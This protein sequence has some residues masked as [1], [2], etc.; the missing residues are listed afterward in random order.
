MRS[1]VLRK[2]E[3]LIIAA[4]KKESAKEKAQEVLAIVCMDEF[5]NNLKK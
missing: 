3:E 1:C 2:E 5:W 4:G